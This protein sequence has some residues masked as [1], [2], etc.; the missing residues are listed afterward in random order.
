MP[1][2]SFGNCPRKKNTSITV[3]FSK[4]TPK[5]TLINSTYHHRLPDTT[6]KTHNDSELPQ[7]FRNLPKKKHADQ[8]DHRLWALPD[9]STP[10]ST[11]FYE[12][13]PVLLTRL[14]AKCACCLR[15]QAPLR[16][17]CV[18]PGRYISWYCLEVLPPQ[19][20]GGEAT[21][22]TNPVINLSFLFTRDFFPPSWGAYNFLFSF[23]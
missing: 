23:F 4:T 11:D 9:M 20:G 22:L 2:S 6:Q 17:F 1:P 15:G 7:A 5:R 8:D 14:F 16:C 10:I 18:D 12:L 21:H 19:G 3:D 13:S